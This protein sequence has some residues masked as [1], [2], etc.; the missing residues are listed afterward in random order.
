MVTQL[1]AELGLMP[2]P[3]EIQSQM[4]FTHSLSS[5]PS[6]CPAPCFTGLSAN[7][8]QLPHSGST[9][10]EHYFRLL[11]GLPCPIA[12]FSK[13]FLTA[14][15]GKQFCRGTCWRQD[16]KGIGRLLENW[17]SFQ[18]RFLLGQSHSP[19]TRTQ[20]S[21]PHRGSSLFPISNELVLIWWA[22]KSKQA[23]QLSPHHH[24]FFLVCH[25]PRW[26]VSFSTDWPPA[27]LGSGNS[28]WPLKSV[29]YHVLTHKI[30]GLERG[31]DDSRD[32]KLISNYISY[33]K[34]PVTLG[35][36]VPCWACFT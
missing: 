29:L 27:C 20:P 22:P 6:W 10:G 32:R 14:P 8:E 9:A 17:A 1:M 24:P 15:Q 16:G 18:I 30:A 31:D 21:P 35:L 4:S 12:T 36:W 19:S 28:L 23:H 13:D 33:L 11:H 34:S 26:S 7:M 3:S 5:V 25:L 2:S